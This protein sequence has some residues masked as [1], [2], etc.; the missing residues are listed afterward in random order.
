MSSTTG[1][2]DLAADEWPVGLTAIADDVGGGRHRVRAPRCR[3]I[4][5]DALSEIVTGLAITVEVEVL[6]QDVL[7]DA[8]HADEALGRSPA[9][10][11]G[12][13][14]RVVRGGV[15]DA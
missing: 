4:D 11:V 3:A 14:A 8:V 2:A 13:H 6:D 1:V 15:D 9:D 7:A 10:I 12:D 5:A